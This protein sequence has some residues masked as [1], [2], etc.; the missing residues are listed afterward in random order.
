MFDFLQAHFFQSGWTCGSALAQT[1]VGGAHQG[2][3]DQ[4]NGALN[5]M[6]KLAHVAGP[7]MF[8]KQLP[9]GWIKARDGFSITLSI[10]AQEML[11]EKGNV[12]PPVAQR[13]QMN[14]DG[15]QA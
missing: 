10:S 3:A 8:V 15:I 5:G 7:G 6:V 4:K 12:V 14:L 9:G 2:T 13:R 11:G 1:E